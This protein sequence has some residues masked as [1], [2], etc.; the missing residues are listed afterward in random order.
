[1]AGTSLDWT[2]NTGV[3]TGPIGSE[4][5][6]SFG[7]PNRLFMIWGI[8]FHKEQF[9]QRNPNGISLKIAYINYMDIE[10]EAYNEGDNRNPTAPENGKYTIAINPSDLD[11]QGCFYLKEPDGNPLI[12]IASILS[13]DLEKG[14]LNFDLIGTNVDFVG[15]AKGKIANNQN[16]NFYWSLGSKCLPTLRSSHHLRSRRKCKK[17]YQASFLIE[18]RFVSQDKCLR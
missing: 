14:N 17:C 9:E 18:Q 11:E 13:L 3:D 8:S 16:Y 6:I 2:L 4:V 12:L 15:M 7:D 1:M 5:V 10:N